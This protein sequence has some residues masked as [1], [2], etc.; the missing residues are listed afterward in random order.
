MKP[1]IY[2]KKINVDFSK[3]KDAV[4]EDAAIALYQEGEAI[5]TASKILCASG[6]RHFEKQWYG[7]EARY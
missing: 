4:V 7:S 6:Y 3:I 1:L 2:V 5:M